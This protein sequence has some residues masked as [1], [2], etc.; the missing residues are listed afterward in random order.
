MF[1]IPLIIKIPNK[2]KKIVTAPTNHYQIGESIIGILANGE[3]DDTPL[4]KSKE[5]FVFFQTSDFQYSIIKND[6]IS[7]YDGSDKLTYSNTWPDNNSKKCQV[8]KCPQK[9]QK[10][11]EYF[12]N[13]EGLY[14]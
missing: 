13:L 10:Y 14:E 3:M 2:K 8:G 7:V 11:F 6:S 12:K 9:F 5:S 4:I 1:H